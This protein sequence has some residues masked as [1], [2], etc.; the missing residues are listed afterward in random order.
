MKIATFNA[1]SIRIRLP[2]I[3]DWLSTAK[4]DVL[5]LQ[6]TKVQDNDFP[7]DAFAG[8][9]YHV[10][11]RGMKSY[12]GVAIVSRKSPDEVTF[13]LRDAPEPIRGAK[14]A[15]RIGG[16]YA[17]AD[18]TRFAHAVFGDLH[19]LNSYVPQGNAIDSPK[20][21]YKLQWFTRLR[22]YFGAHFKKTTP[23]VWCGDLNVAPRDMDV[24]SPKTHLKHPCFHTDVREAYTNTL[25]WGFQDV[26]TQLFPDKPQFTFWDYRQPSSFLANR[27][28]RIDHILATA[29]LASQCRHVEVDV[30]PRKSPQASDH[31]FL[32]AEFAR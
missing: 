3:L 22:T 24:H 16:P 14:E 11:F 20:Y 4:P 31:T 32:W 29:P 15:F 23:V 27:G 6:E 26:Y 5:C 19:V 7:K 9:G 12:N 13:G 2:L 8:T 25:A 28:W 17:Q 10:H 21:L 18:E 1:N 30:E